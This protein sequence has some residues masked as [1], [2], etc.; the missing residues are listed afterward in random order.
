MSGFIS[1]LLPSTAM[2]SDLNPGFHA[3]TPS[4]WWVAAGLVLVRRDG[5]VARRSDVKPEEPPQYRLYSTSRV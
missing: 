3:D 4:W 2:A 1:C 5:H